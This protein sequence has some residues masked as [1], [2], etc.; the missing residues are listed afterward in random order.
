MNYTRA[1]KTLNTGAPLYLPKRSLKTWLLNAFCLSFFCV[2]R[3]HFLGCHV[4]YY[5]ANNLSFHTFLPSVGNFTTLSIMCFSFLSMS[6]LWENRNVFTLI[7]DQVRIACSNLTHMTLFSLKIS[8]PPMKA[9]SSL[10]F[11]LWAG[12]FKAWPADHISA[13]P[14]LSL[15]KGWIGGWVTSHHYICVHRST[16]SRLVNSV[17]RNQSFLCALDSQVCKIRTTLMGLRASKCCPVHFLIACMPVSS[18]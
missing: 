8:G 11:C 1:W 14:H 18:G 5:L 16:T 15:E 10:L 4:V 3:G 9:G 13:P 12:K 6:L 17:G 7:L 2:W